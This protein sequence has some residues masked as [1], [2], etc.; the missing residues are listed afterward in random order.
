VTQDTPS[1]PLLI[2]QFSRT[3]T[4]LRLSLTDR[5]NLRCMYCMPEGEQ[6]RDDQVKT[7]RFLPHDELLS[8]E[9]LLRVV[10]LAVSM[11]MNKLRLTGGEPLV[12]RGVLEFIDQLFLLEGLTEVRLTTNGVLLAEYAERLYS[13]GIRHLNVSLDTLVPGKFTKITGKDYFSH[14]WNGVLEAKRLGF[15]I[16]VNVVAMKGVNDDEFTDF[17]RLA[18]EQP[19][20]VRFIEFMPV[21]AKTTWQKDQFISSEEIKAA[22]GAVGTLTPFTKRHGEGPARM[23]EL[24]GSDGR[25]GTVGF[26]SPIS[27]H[28]CDQCNRL[29][30]TSEGKLRSCLLN[31]RETDLKRLLRGG[32]S[33]EELIGSIRQTILDK[34]KGHSLNKDVTTKERQSCSG[35]MSRIGG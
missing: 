2:D 15:K 23:Y 9:E 20:T 25:T 24:Y 11:G 7:G 32:A 1:A 34:P 19:F 28:F 22:I 4:Y 12:R 13:A 14:V 8:Y 17:A 31:D 6:E 3:I 33:D 16:K 18:I 10:R 21:G 30:L 26:I 27:H 5:C 35:Q 29:R